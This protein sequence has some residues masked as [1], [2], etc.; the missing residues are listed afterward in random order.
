MSGSNSSG[1]YLTAHLRSSALMKAPVEVAAG[2]VEGYR[3]VLD[4][5]PTRELP[6]ESGSFVTNFSPADPWRGRLGRR[7]FLRCC[8]LPSWRLRDFA[9]WRS[10]PDPPRSQR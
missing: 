8:F 5:K 1:A 3:E 6:E 10:L 7:Y 4:L 2:S 9:T